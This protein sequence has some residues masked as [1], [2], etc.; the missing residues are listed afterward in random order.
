[1]SDIPPELLEVHRSIERQ[2]GFM[3][4]VAFLLIWMGRLLIAG[5]IVMLVVGVAHAETYDP[6]NTYCELFAQDPDNG[7]YYIVE[8]PPWTPACGHPWVTVRADKFL[9]LVE[10]FE[11]SSG[12]TTSPPQFTADEVAALKY[13]AA[14][15]SPFNL[16]IPDGSL[17]S[18]AVAATWAL[19]W[20]LKQIVRAI[21]TDGDKESV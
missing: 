10:A 8:D 2:H 4:V 20:V 14:N 12:G 15:P 3:R 9:T 21:N 11:G 13:Q 5:S 7:R 19:A 18:G 16:S 17:V 6:S 1:M